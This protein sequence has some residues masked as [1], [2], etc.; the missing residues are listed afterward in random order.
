MS[1]LALILGLLLLAS[2]VLMLWLLLYQRSRP[3]QLAGIKELVD[4]S[5]S[6]QQALTQQFS[7]A[8]ADMASRLE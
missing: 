2:L 3:S 4:R 7:A 8:T 5:E 6:L 1:S